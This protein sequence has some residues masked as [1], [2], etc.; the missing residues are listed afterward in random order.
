MAYHEFASVYDRLMSDMPYD[1][2]VRF[3]ERAWSD[4]GIRPGTIV[5]LG[6]GTGNVAIPMAARGYD[7]IGI[8]L[9]DDMLA[10]ARQKYERSRDGALSAA[11][12]RIEWVQQDMREWEVAQPVDAVISFCD[13]FN[14]ITE[15]EDVIAAFQ[16]THAALSSGGVFAFDVHMPR[17]LEAYAA[18]QPFVLDEDEV[19]YIWACEYDEDCLEIEHSITFFAMEPSGLFRRFE[20]THVQRAYP[21]DWLEQELK[22]AG[23]V[24]IRI[25]ADFTGKPPG[26]D[27]ERAFFTARKR[28]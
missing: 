27:A 15:P 2:W 7:V 26:H 6:C 24:D 16:S 19:A 11:A 14:Y 8:D 5:D 20:E 10:V 22:A 17:Q 23:F 4:Y 18:S 28:S 1:D 12:G 21:L 13:C 9:S 3:A 25:T